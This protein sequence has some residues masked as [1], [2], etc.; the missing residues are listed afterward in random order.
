MELCSKRVF[1]IDAEFLFCIYLKKFIRINKWGYILMVKQWILG[2]F[3]KNNRMKYLFGISALITSSILQLIIPKLIGYITDCLETRSQSLSTIVMLS[4]AIL[5]T[6]LL[7]FA[8]K[9]L[10]R[11]F[12]M[13]RSRDLECFL[14][15][16]LFSHLQSLPP[17]FYNNKKTGELMSYAINDLNAIRRAFA[18]GLVFLIDGIII[19]LASIVVMGKTIH[20]I[21]TVVTLLPV[22]ISVFFILKL[23]K[24]IRMKF[25]E[26][27][28]AFANISDKV[29]ENISG[30]RVVKAYV[31]EETEIDKLEKA[32]LNRQKIQME[33]VRLSAALSPFVQIC[34]GISFT[35]ALVVGGRYV[36][37]GIISLGDFIAFNTYL[38]LLTGPVNQVGKIVEV[39]QNAVA[40][41]KRLDSIFTVKTDIEDSPSPEEMQL[42]G[43]VNIKNLSF[44]YPGTKEK[45]LKNIN[46]HVSAGNTLAIIGRTGSGKTTI[47]NLLLRLYN[48]ERG[49]IFIDDRDIN[50]IAL[51]ELRGGIGY[52]P[53]DNFLFSVTIR[54]NIQFYNSD[55]QEEEVE[56]AARASA[57]YDNIVDFPDGFNTMVGERGITL[58]GGQKQR[59]S[60]ARALI[61]EPTILILDDSLSAVDTKTEEEILLNIKGI[62]NNRTGIII[63][64]R[65]STIKHADEILFMDKGKIIERGNHETLMEYKGEYFKLYCAQQAE[66]KLYNDKGVAI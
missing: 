28:Q 17:K 43:E 48:V 46:I 15:A 56:E 1:I 24:K 14:R 35:V 32:S 29:Q 6:A 34:F 4:A 54:E 27:Q 61:K 66:S 13:G 26:V 60:I 36:K 23:K 57:V 39:W 7:L 49:K 30:I 31:Q 10:L 21:L 22:L 42:Q 52:V 58:S 55:F 8:M 12:L 38:G 3:L 50:D 62:L 37:M 65:I 53:Q 63:A 59:I 25:T 45:V 5:L 40:S 41:M 44:A 11:Y 9:F 16:K 33:Y 20:P 18:F 2:E 51:S 64:H 19:N 47:A